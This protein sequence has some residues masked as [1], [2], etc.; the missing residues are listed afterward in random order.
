VVEVLVMLV[1]EDETVEAVVLGG[2]FIVVTAVGGT[3]RWLQ[4]F[5]DMHSLS[6]Q[7][8]PVRCNPPHCLQWD[9]LRQLM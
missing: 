1:D 6:G 2:Q 4:K 5:I 3:H 8:D 7:Q 9:W